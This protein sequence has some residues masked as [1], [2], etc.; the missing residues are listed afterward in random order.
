MNSGID[1]HGRIDHGDWFRREDLKGLAYVVRKD[2]NGLQNASEH[3]R[4]IARRAVIFIC[5]NR[6]YHTATVSAS[7][8]AAADRRPEQMQNATAW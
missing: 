3:D 7:A 4:A 1:D 5:T 6:L 8:R 2:I